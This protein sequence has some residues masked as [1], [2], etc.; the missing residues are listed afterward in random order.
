MLLVSFF[1]PGVPSQSSADA[2]RSPPAR[3]M[4]LKLLTRKSSQPEVSAADIHCVSFGVTVE[5]HAMNLCKLKAAA[6]AVAAQWRRFSC[7]MVS[8]FP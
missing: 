5:E 8:L 2:S 7:R 4:L 3:S 6:A 1:A